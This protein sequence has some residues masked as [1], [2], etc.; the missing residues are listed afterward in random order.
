MKITKLITLSAL[1]LT[2]IT[3]LEAVNKAFKSDALK[4][5][6][7]FIQG[8]QTMQ[9]YATQNNL[10]QLSE[11]INKDDSQEASNLLE[12]LQIPPTSIQAE[13]FQLAN[14]VESYLGESNT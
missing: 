11:A 2:L 6:N 7:A 14:A 8:N 3:G 12:N 10:Q 1:A 9:Q 13:W 4:A 5:I